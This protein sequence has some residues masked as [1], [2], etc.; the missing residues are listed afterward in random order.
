M[1]VLASSCP[2]QPDG[3]DGFGRHPI[4]LPR[5]VSEW[6]FWICVSAAIDGRLLCPT[7][8]WDLAGTNLRGLT[9]LG[10]EEE[11]VNLRGLKATGAKLADSQFEN[12]ILDRTDLGKAQLGSPIKGVFITR[13]DIAGRRSGRR[14]GRN[15]T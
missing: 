3:A 15:A 11:P 13:G 9:I 1:L 4:T 12:V 7:A 5:W 10:D 14:S 8:G 2:D 6:L